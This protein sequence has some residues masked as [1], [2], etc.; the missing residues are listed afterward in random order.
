MR[1]WADRKGGTDATPDGFDRSNAFT[2]ASLMDAWFRRLEERAYSPKTIEARKWA[3]RVLL[4]WAE[5]RDLRRPDQ[6]T[7]PILE[8]CQRGLFQY[9]K[10]DGKPLGVT[11]QR[12]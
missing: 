4:H 6:I 11:R 2:L 10:A 5:D 3:L 12:G 8:S 9:R 7:K 1:R